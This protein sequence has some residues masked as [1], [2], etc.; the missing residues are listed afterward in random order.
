MYPLVCTFDPM[1]IDLSPEQPAARAAT[2]NPSICFVS[3]VESGPLE[4]QTVRFAESLRRFGG[5]LADSEI[6][7]VS[8]RFGP[9]LA[10]STRRRFADLGVR[11]VRL[12]SHP[13]YAWYHYLNTPIALAAAEE[14]TDATIICWADS[15]LLIMDEPGEYLL[16]D[17]LDFVAGTIDDGVVGS[18]GPGSAHEG[19]WLRL[20]SLLDID[21]ETLPWVESQMDHQRLRLYFQAG[22]FAYRRGIGFSQYY[23]D[24]CTSVLDQGFGFA[25][26]AENYLDQVCLGLA[27]HKFGL[28]WRQLDLTHNFPMASF[29]PQF[30]SPERLTQAK[31]LHY[32][33][34]MEPHFWPTCVE[35]VS[36]GH[37]E[38]GAWLRERPPL[39]DPAPAPYRLVRQALRIAR[40]VPRKR[41]R[42][43]VSA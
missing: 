5:A 43:R 24:M 38:V 32:H 23:L 21:P 22:V 10:K 29:L 40:G 37:P 16:D 30:E 39:T 33:D 34:A 4:A 42:A 41:Y 19:D 28:R 7:A 27:A 35:R 17:G 31:V 26:R 14:L 3:C 15:D 9:P 6:L 8:P 25:H 13:R 20:L 11:H 2:G 18:T 1:A 12:R 36:A